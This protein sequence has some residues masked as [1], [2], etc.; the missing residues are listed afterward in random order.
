MAE[1]GKDIDTKN[2]A[3]VKSIDLIKKQRKISSARDRCASENMLVI[4]PKPKIKQSKLRNSTSISQLAIPKPKEKIKEKPQSAKIERIKKEVEKEIR[5]FSSNP[6]FYKRT[7]KPD[8]TFDYNTPI[9]KKTVRYRLHSAKSSNKSSVKPL[10]VRPQSSA[11]RLNQTN[12]FNDLL[13]G[14]TDDIEKLHLNNS[15]E[16]RKTYKL[17]RIKSGNDNIVT[18]PE[19]LNLLLEN[20]ELDFTEEIPL[21]G[22]TSKIS[23]P[24]K[25]SKKNKIIEAPSKSPNMNTKLLWIVRENQKS[26]QFTLS[27]SD[28]KQKIILKTLE[29]TILFYVKHVKLQKVEELLKNGVSPN[30]KDINPPYKTLLHIATIQGSLPLVELLLQYGADPTISDDLGCTPLA[31]AFIQ[32]QYHIY[33]CLNKISTK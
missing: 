33:Q 6:A 32:K 1:T 17:R 7:S 22:S 2:R 11:P 31:E 24:K 30:T 18:I 15:N 13:N 16:K 25:V 23:S 10:K 26:F 9:L 21:K 19:K 4:K 20:N 28:T 14:V 5:P 3:R 29:K 12:C 8:L 27:H